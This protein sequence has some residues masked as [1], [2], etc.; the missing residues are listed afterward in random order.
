MKIVVTGVNGMLGT[1]LSARLRLDADVF[2]I[3][4]HNCNILRYETLQDVVLAY[5]PDV[6]IHAAAYTNVDEAERDQDAARQVNV[7]GTQHVAAVAR[8]CGAKMVY[9]STD[10]V[11]DGTK[12]SAYTEEDRPAP[13]GIYG[14]TKWLGEQQV[15]QLL[16]H[17]DR[18]NFLIVRT[19]WL[20]GR[21]GKNFVSA[22]L[23]LA[24]QQ[25][26]LRVVNDQTSS[27]T[28]TKDL[29]EGIWALLTHGASG[30]VHVTNSGQCT[31]YDF[32]R[33]ILAHQRLTH[34]EIE[35]I[36]SEQLQRLAPR[37]KYTVLDTSKFTTVTGQALRPWQ[38]GLRAYF[39]E[40]AI[41]PGQLCPGTRAE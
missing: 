26:R 3:D 41:D 27:P 15:Q 25:P 28:Y 36:T 22:I 40:S 16:T 1:D 21:H 35:A 12:G 37:P 6:I 4:V 9:I 13:L 19:A 18:Q 14:Q 24:E 17:N 5:H 33:A 30:N 29:A 11:F 38:E 2:G 20:Y 32:A 34:I 7:T 31:W 10:Y 23:Q 8:A 39:E